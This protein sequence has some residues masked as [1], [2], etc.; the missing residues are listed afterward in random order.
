M[1]VTYSDVTENAYLFPAF[2]QVL[3]QQVVSVNVLRFP[4]ASH[5]LL[6]YF[7]AY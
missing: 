1:D 5:V 7:Q 2:V 6:V 3:L 4:Q